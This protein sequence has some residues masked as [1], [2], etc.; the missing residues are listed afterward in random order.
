MK[1]YD[2]YVP[3]HFNDGRRVSTASFRRLKHRLIQRF[4]GLTQFPQKQIGLWKV[5]AVTFR[6]RIIILRILS[7]ETPARSRHFW[8]EIKTTL[9]T[10]WK[11]ENVLIVVKT[12]RTL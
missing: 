12:V 5:G 9:K 6:D 3:L 4:G 8:N 7:A 10:Q 11:Q 2:L 1:E